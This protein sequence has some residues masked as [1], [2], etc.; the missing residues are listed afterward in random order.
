M[1]QGG[2]RKLMIICFLSTWEER[3][4]EPNHTVSDEARTLVQSGVDIVV[5]SVLGLGFSCLHMYHVS[6]MFENDRHFSHLSTLEREMTFRTEMGLYYSYYKTLIE[7]PTIYEGLYNLT[8]DNFTEYPLTINTLQRFNL[9]PEV[10]AAF[11]YHAYLKTMN[12]L[13]RPT[14]QCWQVERGHGLSPVTSCEGPGDPI[15]FYLEFVWIFAGLTVMVIFIYGTFLSDSV[16]GGFLSVICFFYNHNECT[17]V[18]WSPP[19]RENFSYPFILMEMYCISMLKVAWC[20]WTVL[21]TWQFS[22]FVLT[23]QLVV[24]VF[25]FTLNLIDKLTLLVIVF[26]QII[27]VILADIALFG[28]EMLLCSLFTCMLLCTPIFVLCL[29]HSFEQSLVY[30]RLSMLT[31]LCLAAILLKIK[32]A[33]LFGN[34]DD[35]HVIYIILS[36]LSKYKDFHT[37]LYTCAPEFDFLPMEMVHKLG[38][39][40]LLPAAGVAILTVMAT[41]LYRFLV[42][43]SEKSGKSFSDFGVE[44]SVMYNILQLCPF[45]VMTVLI[46]RLKLFLTP[47]LCILTSLLAARRS[48]LG[49]YSNIELEQLLTWVNTMT[50]PKAVFAGPM[51]VMANLML[52][53]R[54]PIVNHPHYEN[55]ALRFVPCD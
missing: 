35:S 40:F 45:I 23:T 55:A 41:W 1:R 17:R 46:M 3:W 38:E 32:M 52:S 26:G 20:T 4:G 33:I 49:E 24:L 43:Y 21:V 34:A 44:L 12:Y 15:Y 51:P 28:N 2:A 13:G 42:N 11:L 54:R 19:L 36:K 10:F 30:H 50:T 9:Y 5:T 8:H 47:H 27:G 18:Q 22:Q 53:T 7:A 29:E 37:L 6:T 14:K 48:F 39:T 25:M 16:A 31:L